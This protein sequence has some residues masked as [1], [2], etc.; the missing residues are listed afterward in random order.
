MVAAQSLVTV[1]V[2]LAGPGYFSCER[3]RCRM[4]VE[5][6]IRRQKAMGRT[7]YGGNPAIKY[8]ECEDCAQGKE[9][10][11]MRGE[12]M[13]EKKESKVCRKC[14]EAKPLGEFSMIRGKWYEGKCRECKAVESK[15][16]RLQRNKELEE[17][18]E[19]KKAAP[20]PYEPPPVGT[21]A[22]IEPFG[23]VIDLGG[24]P[25]VADEL[26]EQAR[27]NIR[28]VEHQAL[29]YIVRGLKEVRHDA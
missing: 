19:S 10:R 18:K 8:L 3:F 7:G 27:M 21:P 4:P 24:Y 12:T 29:Y 13:E 6:C 11:R 5:T 28:T 1:E 9:N 15:E 14:G 20:I 16:R 25:E 17:L 23:L 26:V 22:A 2:I